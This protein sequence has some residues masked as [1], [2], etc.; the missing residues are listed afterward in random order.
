MAAIC[1][2]PKLGCST[3]FSPS[4]THPFTVRSSSLMKHRIYIFSCL[5]TKCELRFCSYQVEE[6]K[7]SF[8]G[9]YFEIEG[10]SLNFH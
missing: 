8:S 9:D 4:H 2:P 1:P 3:T 5:L 6:D 7:W 10:E